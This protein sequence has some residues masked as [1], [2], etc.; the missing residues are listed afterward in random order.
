MARS[1]RWDPC[2]S[3][4]GDEASA[5]IKAY[6]SDASRRVLFIAGA[7][8][9]PRSTVV[10]QALA[11]SCKDLRAFLVKENRPDAEQ[12]LVERAE[13]NRLAFKGLFEQC[14]IVDVDIFGSDG[15]V[16]GGR[17][18]V[19]KLDKQ[20]FSDRTDVVID[21]SALSVGTS[22]PMV[23][24]LFERANQ[25]RPPANIH[26]FVAHDPRLDDAIVPIA[27]D[28]AGYV[29]G[30][31][32]PATLGS[33][34]RAAKLWLPQ[35]ARERR[36]ALLRLHSFV[37]PHD[38]C[39]ILPFPASNPRHGDELVADFIAEFENAW[40]VDTRNVVYGAEDDPLDLYRTILRLDDLRRPV[41]QEFGG[42]LLV[43]SPVGS[44]IMA[45]GALLAALER[46]LPVAHLESIGY[47]FADAVNVEPPAPFLMHIW[48]E[49]DVYPQPRPP[50]NSTWK[51]AA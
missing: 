47:T 50:L 7:G 26:V 15:A 46:D 17:N 51:P 4:R 10:G 42:S 27:G 37:D 23:K 14:E 11:E 19:A 28:V 39:P 20:E 2:I 13:V 9:D 6:F 31:R 32:G 33:T 35:L 12:D 21:M 48:L 36:G 16:V 8:F 5:F 45:L 22:F 41:F 18:I 34:S 38:T 40:S 1:L 24:Y 43:L 29:H 25:A 44:K 30:F 3:H 49:G